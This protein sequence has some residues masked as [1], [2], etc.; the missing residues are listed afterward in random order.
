MR[1]EVAGAGAGKT[2][3]MAAHILS[4]DIPRGKVVYCVAFTNAAAN[5]ISSRIEQI[6]GSVPLNIKVSTIHSFLYSE[7]I[8]PYYHL[9]YG[10]HYQG[11]SVI[12]LPADQKYRNARIQELD[13]NNLLH[14]TAIP[15]RAKWLV[16]KKSKDSVKVKRT[17]MSILKLFAGYCHALFVDEAQDIDSNMKAI[18]LAL[19]HAGVEMNLYGDPKQDVRGF[20]CLR[21][22]INACDNVSYIHECHRCPALHLLLSN[23]LASDSEKQ[24]ADNS[25][26]TGSINVYLE[27]ETDVRK[28]ISAQQ[29]GLVYISRKN[30]RFETHAVAN[31]SDNPHF[32]TLFHEVR[33]AVSKKYASDAT[34]IEIERMAF[35]ASKQMVA[36]ISDGDKPQYVLNSWIQRRIFDYSA[37]TYAKVIAALRC[38]TKPVSRTAIPVSSIEAVKGL[39]SEKCLF[40]LTLDLAPYLFGQNSQD[41][42]MKH[43]LYVALTRSLD[44]LSI[45]IAKEV[46]ERYSRRQ[47]MLLEKGRLDISLES[48]ASGCK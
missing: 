13:S 4:R 44:N 32:D 33:L 24:V 20:G 41:N 43:L 16:D 37:A 40:I 25:N 17:R 38:A 27:S 22:L 34:S 9:L 8:Q 21:E 1:I 19:D 39:E 42:R 5:N 2:T 45:L 30:N 11:V 23:T 48:D 26:C 35:N 6:C 7:L 14:Q 15:Q 3:N 28:L 46:E 10:K 36:A 29:Y 12:E 18:L 31:R 47:L